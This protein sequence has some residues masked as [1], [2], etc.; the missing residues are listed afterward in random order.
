VIGKYLEKF[1]HEKGNL[2][3]F[4]E[5]FYPDFL[6]NI[7]EKVQIYNSDDMTGL[8]IDLKKYQSIYEEVQLRFIESNREFYRVDEPVSLTLEIKNIP[9][10]YAKIFEFNTETYYKK[11]LQPFNTSVNLDGLVASGEKVYEYKYPPNKKVIQTFDFPELAGKIG[12]FIVE[13][14]G[15]GMSARAVIKKGSLSFIHKPT[16]AGHLAYILDENKRICKGSNTGIYFDGQYY[17]AEEG[18]IFIPYGKQVLTSKVI[19]MNN[20]FAQLSDFSRQTEEYEFKALIAI[21]P[22]SILIGKKA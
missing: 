9:T 17:K 22:E 10:L 2:E 14:I 16:I 6:K 19:L 18:K 12:L 5:D 1:C 3:S 4:S 8:N 20:G 13:L 21:N 15:N 7:E 11:T